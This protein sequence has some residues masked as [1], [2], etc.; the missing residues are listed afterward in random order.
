M[1]MR[2]WIDGLEHDPEQTPTQPATME[3]SHPGGPLFAA[4]LVAADAV[5]VYGVDH[6]AESVTVLHIG[7]DPPPYMS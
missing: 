6:V 3:H 4:F 5:I 7:Q 2:E 1:V